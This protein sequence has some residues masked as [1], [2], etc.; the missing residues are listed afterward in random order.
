[1][2]GTLYKLLRDFSSA[3][4]CDSHVDLFDFIE[5]KQKLQESSVKESVSTFAL[6]SW[7]V[8]FITEENTELL[9]HFE[10]T[11]I[12]KCFV[13][14]IINYTVAARNKINIQIA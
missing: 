6:K 3:K 7:R 4:H 5:K 2:T 1:M 13:Y 9:N 14:M 10:K 12:L 8:V 11:I